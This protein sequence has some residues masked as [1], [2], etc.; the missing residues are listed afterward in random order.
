MLGLL[1]KQTNKII[2]YNYTKNKP[3]KIQR[4][5]GTTASKTPE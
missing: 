2:L 4:I 3:F 5:Y 1:K